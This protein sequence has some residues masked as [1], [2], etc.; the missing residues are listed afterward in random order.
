MSRPSSLAW[1]VAALFA[2]ALAVAGTQLAGPPAAAPSGELRLISLSP[3]I[4]ETL[5][6]L[7][8][9][10]LLV[11]R[12]DW[13]AWPPEVSTLPAVGSALTPNLEAIVALH[14]SHILTEA[15]LA[16][17]TD[18]LAALA[19]TEVLPWLTLDD[20]VA[21]VRRLGAL[22]AHEA[23]ANTLA[24]QLHS[25]L[26]VVPPPDA[27]RVLVLLGLEGLARG[28][29]W[30]VKR[31]SLHGAAMH[32]AGMRN[33]MDVDVSGAPSMSV[34]RLLALDPDVILSIVADS[35]DVATSRQNTRDALAALPL[36]AVRDGA[37]GA[38]VGPQQFNTGPSV[39]LLADALRDELARIRSTTP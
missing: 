16:G 6:A 7:G 26:G 12:S 34:E 24:D 36:R 8:A 20:L 21:S 1:I 3:P 31:G 18:Q 15:T 19:N 14:P 10:D 30:Y 37:V 4:T 35:T 33:A 28:E 11:A 25:R 27:P 2:V 23:Q 32:A 38:L 5:F 39:L 29:V 22:T 17:R 9:G 13:C